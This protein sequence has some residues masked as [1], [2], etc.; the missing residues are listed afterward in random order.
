MKQLEYVVEQGEAITFVADV[1]A[2]K[3]A[4]EFHGADKAVCRKLES[5]GVLIARMQPEAGTDALIGGRG[6]VGAGHV[7]F[8]GTPAR[9]AFRYRQIR[10]FSTHALV[11]SMRDVPNVSTIAMTIH[12]VGY[13]LDEVE[14]CLAQFD[15]CLDA[16]LDL[17]V[18]PD[19]AGL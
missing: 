16:L 18:T 17:Q 14:S 19:L 4:R 2:L 1:L 9:M 6:I 7:L 15:G 5:A 10:S 12:G 3:Y 8:I 11:A 13:G